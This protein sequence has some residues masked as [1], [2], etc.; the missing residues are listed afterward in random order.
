LITKYI[1]N[2][3]Q[4]TYKEGHYVIESIKKGVVLTFKKQVADAAKLVQEQVSKMSAST[5]PSPTTLIT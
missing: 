5:T 3:I 2:E 1:L 4:D